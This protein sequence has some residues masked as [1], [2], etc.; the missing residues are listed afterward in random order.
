MLISYKILTMIDLNIFLQH[1]WKNLASFIFY[2]YNYF[3]TYI[4]FK[5]LNLLAGLF[6][7]RLLT[8]SPKV[9]LRNIYLLAIWVF[10][11][12]FKPF[13][14]ILL[15]CFTLINKK[16]NKILTFMT[17]VW[18]NNYLRQFQITLLYFDIF[19]RKPAISKFD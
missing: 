8:F 19:R 6:P 15:K 16:V 5:N 1:G 9:C 4:Q 10:K 2:L 7:F 13:V 11:S 3:H 18:L 12:L 14:F 17:L